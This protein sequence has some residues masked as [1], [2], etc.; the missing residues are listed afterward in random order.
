MF[1]SDLVK[2]VVPEFSA[3]LGYGGEVRLALNG[4]HSSI[5]KY[6]SR[7][8][9]SYRTISRTLAALVRDA[10]NKVQQRVEM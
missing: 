4:D 6:S 8:D 1:N 7:E 10:R 2:I 9:S 3:T 5:V